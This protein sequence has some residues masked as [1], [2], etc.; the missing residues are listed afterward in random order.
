MNCGER[1]IKLSEHLTQGTEENNEKF[2]VL[3]E[4]DMR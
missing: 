2:G 1:E 4:T 3:G